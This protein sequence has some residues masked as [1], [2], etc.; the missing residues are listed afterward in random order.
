MPALPGTQG[1]QLE[2]LRTG[3]ARTLPA[4]RGFDSQPDV[5][6]WKP[7]AE[8]GTDSRLLPHSTKLRTNYLQWGCPALIL[9]SVDPD[10]GLGA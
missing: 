2:A 4:V 8:F 1:G 10:A 6:G 3:S 5:D 9:G 7:S